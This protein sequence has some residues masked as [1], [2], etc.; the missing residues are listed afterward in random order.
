MFSGPWQEWAPKA[1]LALKARALY[2]D[3]FELRQRL[4]RDSAMIELVWG[5]G[6]SPGPPNVTA[7]CR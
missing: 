7:R 3:L 5:H 2:E 6:I 1:R 4:Q